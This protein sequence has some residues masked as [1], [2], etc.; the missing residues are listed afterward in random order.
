[1]LQKPTGVLSGGFQLRLHLAKVL[2]S[3]P[4]CLLLDEPTNYLDILSLRFLRKFLQKWKRELILISHDREF[5][6]S[7]STH[8]LGIHRNKVK[9]AQGGTENLYFQIVQEEELFEKQRLSQ[10]KKV[11]HLQSFIDRFGAKATKAS[12]A[13]AR[14]KALEKIPALEELKKLA[15]LDFSFQEAPHNPHKLLEAKS[16]SFSYTQDSTLIHNV[17]LL[18]ERS[19]RIAIIG[20]NG[21]GKSTLLSLLAGELQPRTGCINPSDRLSLGYFGQTNIERLKISHSIE[22]EIAQANPLLTYTAIKQIAG[23]MMFPGTFPRKK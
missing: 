14:K 4:D 1:M 20:K 17:S 10:G 3:D 13:Q 7:I 18:I 5:L 6:D 16:L 22:E 8:T 21:Y 19:S 23:S 11:A 9:K 12:Q 2:L 15:A